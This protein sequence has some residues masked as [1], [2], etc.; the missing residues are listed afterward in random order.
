MLRQNYLGILIHCEHI[1]IDEPKRQHFVAQRVLNR[2][3]AALA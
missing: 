2:S 1:E 3:S